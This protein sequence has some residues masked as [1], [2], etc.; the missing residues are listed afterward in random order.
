MINSPFNN[1]QGGNV[2]SIYTGSK[3]PPNT[4]LHRYV[5]L[6]YRQNSTDPITN[7]PVVNGTEGEGKWNVSAWVDQYGL[8]KPIA[9]NYFMVRLGGRLPKRIAWFSL[10]WRLG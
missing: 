4:C 3:P 1:L 6:V 8:Q 10:N 9:G 5:F 7:M 2:T